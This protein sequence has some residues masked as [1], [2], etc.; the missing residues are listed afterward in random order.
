MIGMGEPVIFSSAPLK[1]GCFGHTLPIYHHEVEY[2]FRVVGY[3][4]VDSLEN[5]RH[6]VGKRKSPINSFYARL[7]RS[8]KRIGTRWSVFHPAECGEYFS[9][10]VRGTRPDLVDWFIRFVR[11]K[12]DGGLIV[13]PVQTARYEVYVVLD[14]AG[15]EELSRRYPDQN[16]ISA[17]ERK[18]KKIATTFRLP[19]QVGQ[20][21]KIRSMVVVYQVRRKNKTPGKWKAEI[22]PL[23]ENPGIVRFS[24]IKN[25]RCFTPSELDFALSKALLGLTKGIPIYEKPGRWDGSRIV[26]GT[27]TLSE[28][29]RVALYLVDKEVPSSEWSYFLAPWL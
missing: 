20:K 5:Y 24:R 3:G 27:S 19:V 18:S 13:F 11:D 16:L 8:D 28:R 23:T 10:Y 29:K 1:P 4:A 21:N 12:I 15:A 14:D 2:V 25:N 7:S 9:A 26:F 17:A 22:R 6:R